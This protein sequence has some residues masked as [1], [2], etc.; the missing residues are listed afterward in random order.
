[1]VGCLLV[2]IVNL[3]DGRVESTGPKIKNCRYES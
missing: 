2:I 3:S 1:M